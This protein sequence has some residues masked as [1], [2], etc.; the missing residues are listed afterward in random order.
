MKDYDAGAR[1]QEGTTREF[2]LRGKTFRAK[3]AMPGSAFDD[4]ADL[5]SGKPTTNRIFGLLASIIRRTLVADSREAWDELC[6]PLECLQL[7]L[8]RALK[9][10]AGERLCDEFDMTRRRLTDAAASLTAA[11]AGETKKL[12]GAICRPRTTGC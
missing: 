1:E 9:I 12:D 4:L 7:M 11:I 10:L 5:Q 8:E 2:T 3:P 6:D